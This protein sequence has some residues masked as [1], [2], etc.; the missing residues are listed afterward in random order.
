MAPIFTR[1]IEFTKPQG[2]N[3]KGPH[4][5]PAVTVEVIRSLLWDLRVCLKHNFLKKK[6]IFPV[7]KKICPA[8]L[9][10]SSATNLKGQNIG[11]QTVLWH[12][13]LKLQDH[14]FRTN[15]L[16]KSQI[17]ELKGNLPLKKT[18]W[19]FFCTIGCN[20]PWRNL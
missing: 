6:A 8:F 19:P 7:K 20:K 11:V 1:I 3:Y 9:A 12:L 10:F 17:F 13:L 14:F 18:N 16:L 15:S 5:N 2:T 4:G